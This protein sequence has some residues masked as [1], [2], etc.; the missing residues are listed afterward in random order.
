MID[1]STQGLLDFL[2]HCRIH[3]VWHNLYPDEVG[4]TYINP[5][6]NQRNSCIDMLFCSDVLKSQCTMCDI[7]QSPSSDHKALCL[8]LR[9]NTKKRGRGYWKINNGIINQME[10]EDGI[11]YIYDEICN[12]YEQHVSK[13][14][15][16]EYEWLRS[17]VSPSV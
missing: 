15:L 7:Y 4:Y 13:C 5:S 2:D 9:P 16:W 14:M 10:F 1:K 11:H 3:D 17:L 8:S 12:E 6:S